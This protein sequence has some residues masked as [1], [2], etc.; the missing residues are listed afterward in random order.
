MDF[1]K[2][3]FPGL[4]KNLET[5]VVLFDPSKTEQLL[6]LRQVVYSLLPRAPFRI[7]LLPV[8]ST[9]YAKEDR[10]QKQS[11]T[12][13]LIRIIDHLKQTKSANAAFLFLDKV[14]SKISCHLLSS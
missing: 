3:G 10:Q 14:K 5:L 2:N 12:P 7:G 8:D 11:N 6:F 9:E 1:E 4:A 13:L